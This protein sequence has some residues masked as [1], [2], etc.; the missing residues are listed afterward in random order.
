MHEVLDEIQDHEHGGHLLVEDEAPLQD[1]GL[2]QSVQ[3]VL[4]EVQELFQE[5]VRGLLAHEE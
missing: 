2:D 3:R 4:V 5:E 1:F